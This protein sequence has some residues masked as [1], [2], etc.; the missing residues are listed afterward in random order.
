VECR[1]PSTCTIVLV[2]RCRTDQPDGWFPNLT[3]DNL[4]NSYVDLYRGSPA[5]KHVRCYPG[6]GFSG[7]G[8]SWVPLGTLTRAA[9]AA[10][11]YFPPPSSSCLSVA[12]FHSEFNAMS[13]RR[14]IYIHIRL[15]VKRTT[16][17]TERAK[18]EA[19]TRSGRGEAAS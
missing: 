9:C 8:M 19:N 12:K 4:F 16:K 14:Q 18:C 2:F 17:V 7:R 6:E 15:S 3:R 10:D 13:V 1:T 5:W 11:G